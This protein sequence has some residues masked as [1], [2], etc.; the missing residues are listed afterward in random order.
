M[1]FYK[2]DLVWSKEGFTCSPVRNCVFTKS[3]NTRRHEMS[4]QNEPTL[5][6]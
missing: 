6:R 4:Q 5:N 3:S 1:I 2:E